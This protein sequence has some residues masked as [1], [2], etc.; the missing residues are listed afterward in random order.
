MRIAVIDIETFGDLENMS[1]LDYKYLRLRG[2][3][4]TDEGVEQSLAFNPYLLHIISVAITYLEGKDIIEGKVYYLSDSQEEEK[5]EQ[6]ESEG[7]TIPVS[8]CPIRSSPLRQEIS[9]GE[10]E[11]LLRFWEEISAIDRLV[12]YNGRS[13]DVPILCIRSMIHQIEVK[14]EI[15]AA[16]YQKFGNF[17]LDLI[18]FL[19]G[20]E[21]RFSFQLDFVCR[22][23]GIPVKKIMDGSKVRDTFLKGD[24]RAIAEYNYYDTLMTALLYLKVAPYLPEENNRPTEKQ[25]NFLESL[26]L[27]DGW[28]APVIQRIFTLLQ[29]SG[30]F[31]RDNVS[32]LIDYLKSSR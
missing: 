32:K 16:R 20:Q 3:E 2:G 10:R 19:A 9:C 12:T 22:K 14:R 31:T 30:I 4:K 24:Y 8:Y 7:R 21:G 18:E 5:K 26:M 23:F 11:M 25:L 28:D 17:H 15:L 27:G 1:Y 29:E 13:F 6:L